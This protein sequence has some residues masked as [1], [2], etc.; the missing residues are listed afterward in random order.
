MTRITIDVNDEWLEA[1][2]AVLGTQTK[3]ATVNEALRSFAVRKQ[4]KEIMTALDNAE[5]DF[6]D[7]AQA[8]RLG[9]GRDLS[10]V[11]EDAR[12]PRSA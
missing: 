4:A 5:M 8:W 2:R 7:S 3:V 10:R 11:V 12:E 9:G 1:A 6:T